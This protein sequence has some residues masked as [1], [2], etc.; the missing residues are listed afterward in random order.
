MTGSVSA[1][2][3]DPGRDLGAGG[4]VL[5]ETER[6]KLLVDQDGLGE[7]RLLAPSPEEPRD[8]DEDGLR[9]TRPP[10]RRPRPP[11]T[12]N[13]EGSRRAPSTS[14]SKS[15]GTCIPCPPKRALVTLT[16]S[17]VNE[18]SRLASPKNVGPRT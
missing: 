14:C 1:A 6:V 18:L 8:A 12:R 17:M 4:W 11:G 5:E 2:R 13:P 10:D 15:R 3:K 16:P 9:A 7:L